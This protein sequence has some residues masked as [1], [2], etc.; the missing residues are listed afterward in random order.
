MISIKSASGKAKIEVKTVNASLNLPGSTTAVNTVADVIQQP[1]T[2]A[3]WNLCDLGGG[4]QSKHWIKDNR[5]AL[6]TLLPIELKALSVDVFGFLEIKT[7]HRIAKQIKDA[8]HK[9]T[10]FEIGVLTARMFKWYVDNGLNQDKTQP[11]R[12]FKELFEEFSQIM[13]IGEDQHAYLKNGLMSANEYLNEIV[14]PADN[15]ETILKN[16]IAD[17]AVYLKTT[18]DLVGFKKMYRWIRGKL[19]VHGIAN[20]WFLYNDIDLGKSDSY[21]D[22]FIRKDVFIE[23]WDHVRTAFENFGAIPE[24]ED[25]KDANG[26][27]LI[28]EALDV[29]IKDNDKYTKVI[30]PK[31]VGDGETTAFAYDKNKFNLC[32]GGAIPVE[33]KTQGWR[34]RSAGF[35]HLKCKPGILKEKDLMVVAWHAPSEGKRGDRQP[36]Y[37]F[38]NNK[39]KNRAKLKPCLQ[40]TNV[41]LLADMNIGQKPV[42]YEK[43]IIEEAYGCWLPPKDKHMNFCTSVKFTGTGGAQWNHPFDKVLLLKDEKVELDIEIGD[44][45][46]MDKSRSAQDIRKL[47]DHSWVKTEISVKQVRTAST[48]NQNQTT[49]STEKK[50]FSFETS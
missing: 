15:A 10:A 8:K 4:Y 7:G 6:L 37:S 33:E 13:W 46:K 23:T 9:T 1:V 12:S 42:Y 49:T 40:N 20:S 47:S 50:I 3:V 5:S 18:M 48:T 19:E 22:E 27:E 38:V 44:Y 30:L 17:G 21:W 28:T 14:Y 34:F 43:N 26:I 45:E 41:V 2:F 16:M 29:F 24:E 11:P 31:I 36:S 35:I 25:G 39:L 32:C